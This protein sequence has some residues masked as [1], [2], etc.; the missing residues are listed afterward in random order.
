MTEQC[1]LSVG[2][3]IGT[4]T[5]QLIFSEITIRNSASGFS[6]PKMEIADKKILYKSDIHFTPLKSDTEIDADGVLSIIKS[7]YEKAGYSVKDPKTGAIII[8]GETAR[9]ENAKAV[10]LKMSDFSGDFVVAT[11]GADLESV[12]S[13][14]GAG[15]DKIS[16]EYRTTCANLDIGGGTTNVSVFNRGDTKDTACFDI[17][18]RIIRFDKNRIVTHI[19]PKIQDIINRENINIKIG[20]TL[21]IAELDKLLDITVN[22]LCDI[23]REN[24]SP[25][26][27][28]LMTHKGLEFKNISHLTFS[29][30]VAEGIYN[31]FEDPYIFGDIGLFLGK[32]IRN[33]SLFTDFTVLSPKETIRA[34]VVG[35]GSHATKISGSTVYYDKELLPLKSLPVLKISDDFLEEYKKKREWF[36]KNSPVAISIDIPPSP[37][38]ETV[39]RIAKSICKAVGTA[40]EP[41]IL[42]SGNDMGKALGYAIKGIHPSRKIIS[43]DSVSLSDGDYID[44]GSPIMGGMIL[45]VVVKTILFQ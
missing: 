33:S 11:A 28:H 27:G 34:T 43:I 29:G 37:T 18:G 14:K 20:T 12:L 21:D 31:D 5:T 15:T 41:I 1:I 44:I 23:F 30:G 26:Y 4:S 6:V 32:K 25:Y 22:V 16:E 7:E 13:G 2:I 19:T 3:D 9:K 8:T 36:D 17:G 35:A 39:S 24:H 40:N 45:P 42:I 38:Y 10:L